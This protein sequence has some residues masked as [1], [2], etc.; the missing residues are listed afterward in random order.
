MPRPLLLVEDEPAVRE[1]ASAVLSDAGFAVDALADGPDPD[2]TPWE[3]FHVVVLDVGLPNV[4]GM[5]LCRSI[6]RRS[7]VP[8]VMLTARDRADDVVAGLEAGAD[9]Y[10][11]KPFVPAVLVARVEAAV[12]RQIPGAGDVRMLVGDLAI[13]ER[14]FTAS[15]GGVALDLTGT[16]MRLLVALARRAGSVCTRQDLLERVWGYDYLGDSRL[17]DMAVLRL[18]AKLREAGAG[19]DLIQTVR[20]EGYRLRS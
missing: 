5:D 18:R 1:L 2:R 4:D 17:V 11:T 13:D 14:A 8:I 7:N 9:D 16:E 19:D 3:R 10:L 20:G 12:R 6:R 15:R